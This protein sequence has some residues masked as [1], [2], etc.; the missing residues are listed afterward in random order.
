MKTFRDVLTTSFSE[1]ESDRDGERMTVEESLQRED[2]MLIRREFTCQVGS[3][4]TIESNNAATC[5]P[6]IFESKYLECCLLQNLYLH[7]RKITKW[8]KKEVLY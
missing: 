6:N 5:F 8:F 7:E 1:P 3:T 4:C 2:T